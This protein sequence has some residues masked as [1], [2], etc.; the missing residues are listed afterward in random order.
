MT[1]IQ[2]LASVVTPV[3]QRH[4]VKKA[5]FFGS[6]VRGDFNEQTSDIDIL[7]EPPKQMS[8]VGFSRLQLELKELLNRDVDLVSY[9]GMSKY[10]KNSILENQHVFYE[11]Q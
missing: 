11:T 5:A 1:L 10:L 6:L 4:N 3:M 9:N 2:T 8:L 7:I